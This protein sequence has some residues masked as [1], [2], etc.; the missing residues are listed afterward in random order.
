MTFHVKKATCGAE[1]RLLVLRRRV[2]HPLV[3]QLQLLGVRGPEWGLTPE[4]VLL[5]ERVLIPE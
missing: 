4:W 2:R 5:P 1:T 3:S